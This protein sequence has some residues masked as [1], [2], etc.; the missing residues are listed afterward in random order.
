MSQRSPLSMKER[1]SLLVRMSGLDRLSEPAALPLVAR[2][3]GVVQ[4][5]LVQEP[6][7]NE[8]TRSVGR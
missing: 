2:F 5:L 7:V 6:S 3:L 8:G 1:S 4:Q